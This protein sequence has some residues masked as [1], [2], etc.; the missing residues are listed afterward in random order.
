[1]ILMWPRS[2]VKVKLEEGS[3][4]MYSVVGSSPT[5]GSSFF[6]G[7]VTALGVLSCFAL[8]VCLILL[9]SFFLPSHLSLKHVCIID[10]DTST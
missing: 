4:Y 5:Q 6:L 2:M 7:K 8:F 10:R 1:M 3:S 9:S